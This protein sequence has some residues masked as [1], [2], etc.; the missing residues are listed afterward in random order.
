MTDEELRTVEIRVNELIR[1]AFPLVEKRD[2]TMEE[3]RA[4]GA[5]ALFGE[6]Y[7]DV[8]RVVRFGDSVELCGGTHT[9]NTG[10]IGLFKIVSESAVAAGV[11]RIEAVTG[12]KAMENL[13]HMED[14]LKGLKN[15]MNNVPDLQGAIEKLVAENADARKQLEAVA[16][17]KAAALAAKLEAEAVEIN[18][19]K[20]VRYDHSSDPA[21]V[22]NVAL[23]L[24]KK[25]ENFV[26]AGAFAYDNKPNLVLLYSNDLVA[27]GK[28]AG[29]DIREAAKFIQGGGGG[30][31]G[32]ATAGGR[33]LE[34]LTDALNKLVEVA[35]A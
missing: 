18:G 7:G 1:S 2:A 19:I 14:L 15:L 21:I 31:S 32:L 3:A 29:K 20:V 23:L 9:P 22:R 33:N 8:V 25:V 10:T 17:E 34:G 12:A 24:Q 30:Q 13:H 4:M 28:N 5:M 11:R 16:N 6:K 27:K 26:L 35:T